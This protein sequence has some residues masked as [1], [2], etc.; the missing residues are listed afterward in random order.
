MRRAVTAALAAVLLSGCGQK[1][2]LYLPDKGA[3]VITSPP[4]AEPA[5][6]PAAP[7]PAPKAKDPQDDP[8]SP[9]PR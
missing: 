6:P 4:A 3:T 5:P 8:Q 9:P 2:A 1:G 7:A